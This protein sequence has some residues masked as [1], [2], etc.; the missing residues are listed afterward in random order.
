M[1]ELNTSPNLTRFA[2]MHGVTRD[3]V[4][5]I[6]KHSFSNHLD[7][8]RASTAMVDAD[9]VL[10]LRDGDGETKLN[11]ATIIFPVIS[12]SV[13]LENA[14]GALESTSNDK[15]DLLLLVNGSA[16]GGGLK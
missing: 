10:H 1:L 3:S 9:G 4:V 11:V 14:L 13:V 12:R 5:R 16:R 7:V 8:L 2:M 6:L 15:S